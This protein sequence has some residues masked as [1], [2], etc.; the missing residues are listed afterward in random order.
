MI[1]QYIFIH[2]KSKKPMALNHV[3]MKFYE[4]NYFEEAY[5]INTENIYY[6]LDLM[7]VYKIKR[8]AEIHEVITTTKKVKI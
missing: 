3:T 6:I 8:K 5:K 2:K 1:K 4:T 7:R